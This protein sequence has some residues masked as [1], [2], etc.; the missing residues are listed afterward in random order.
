MATSDTTQASAMKGA[1]VAIAVLAIMTAVP[2]QAAADSSAL[3]FELSLIDRG[4]FLRLSELPPGV[5]VVNFW[6][7]DCPPC[8]AEL[9]L[10]VEAA[11]RLGFRLVT[12]SL[13]TPGETRAHWPRIPGDPASH[14]AL[15]G[16]SEPRGLLR[17]FGNASGAI[18]YSAMLRP[19]GSLC[20]KHTGE[21]G[22]DWI[23]ENLAKCGT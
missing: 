17:R 12:I 19:D 15:L 6:R 11:Q 4:G 20:A 7:A 18:P 21:I 1:M 9:P 5:T 10:L 16:P 13:Q 23:R 22:L 3:D 2:A 8:V 14:V